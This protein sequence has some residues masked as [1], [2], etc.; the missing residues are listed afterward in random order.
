MICNQHSQMAIEQQWLQRQAVAEPPAV[1]PGDWILSLGDDWA[2]LHPEEGRWYFF[3]PIH[4]DWAPSGI[5]VGEAILLTAGGVTGAKRL[6]ADDDAE[7][8]TEQKINRLTDWC[9]LLKGE[10]LLGPL[11]QADL[12]EEAD[13]ETRYWSP[14]F[15]R[16]MTFEEFRTGKSKS[17]SEES[18][19][20]R[21]ELRDRFCTQCGN[22]IR[23]ATR[24]CSECGTA[25]IRQIAP[26]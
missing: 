19:P 26:N 8:S 18:A 22:R 24:F 10:E 1:E 5:A 25:V 23:P 14:R 4:A 2:F 13:E 11:Q 20:P 15:N 21:Q 16:W 17:S 3:D 7:T 12:P 6:P 9:V